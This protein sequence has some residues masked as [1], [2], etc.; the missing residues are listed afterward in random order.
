MKKNS[1]LTL[2]EVVVALAVFMIV[3]AMAFPI[4]AQSGL[5]NVK[6][7]E[8]LDAQ[9]IGILVVEE[10]LVVSE[11]Q[12]NES[13]LISYLDNTGLPSFGQ[14]FAYDST[15]CTI[16]KDNYTVTLL[17]NNIDTSNLVKVSV[18][19]DNMKY[20]TLEWLIYD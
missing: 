11:S 5:I 2:V 6:S 9:E 18:N 15:V 14:P 20:E 7:K 8:K 3:V 12:T 19:V 13:T 17:F 16:N 10:L 1:G 4:L